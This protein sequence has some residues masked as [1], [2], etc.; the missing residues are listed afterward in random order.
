MW[1]NQS[2]M[3]AEFTID[4]LKR[5]DAMVIMKELEAFES[6]PHHMYPQVIETPMYHD[7]SIKTDL[8]RFW[9]C[10]TY[11]EED[12][13]A[14]EKLLFKLKLQYSELNLDRSEATFSMRR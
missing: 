8:A 14:A 2:F 5:K 11:K 3:R 7:R 6:I 10:L 1:Y 4:S 12:A 9:F 13:E